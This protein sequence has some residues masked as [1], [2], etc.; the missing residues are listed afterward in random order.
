MLID[1]SKSSLLIVD[2]QE[3]LLP[4]MAPGNSVVERSKIL[5]KSTK[6]L[7]VHI[8]VSEQY[9]KGVGHSGETLSEEIGSE[10]AALLARLF[11]VAIAGGMSP[12]DAYYSARDRSPQGVSEFVELV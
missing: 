3:R 10:D 1:A 5:L 2:V 12:E 9:P 7:D 8:A 4:A 6:A 11:W